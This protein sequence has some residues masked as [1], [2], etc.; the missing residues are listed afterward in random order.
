MNLLILLALALMCHSWLNFILDIKIYLK[1]SWRNNLFK[2]FT[3]RSP[4]FQVKKKPP[5]NMPLKQELDEL[6]Q[7]VK[8]KKKTRGMCKDDWVIQLITIW[9]KLKDTSST[10]PKLG[11]KKLCL[12]SLFHSIFIAF[13][14]YINFVQ[15]IVGWIAIFEWVHWFVYHIALLGGWTWV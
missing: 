5:K 12:N 9:S 3:W 2:S 8:E 7:K 15:N 1:L 4:S 10:W 6:L 13:R 11:L 14:I